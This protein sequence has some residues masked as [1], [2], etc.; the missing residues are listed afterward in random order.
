MSDHRGGESGTH[1]R[2]YIYDEGPVGV[3]SKALKGTYG[4]SV[5]I[6][7]GAFGDCHELALAANSGAMID[8]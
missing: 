1:E 6:V 4:T 2:I 5:P 7:Q 8:E 3:R